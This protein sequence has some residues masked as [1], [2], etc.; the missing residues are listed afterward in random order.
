MREDSEKLYSCTSYILS[1]FGLKIVDCF[2]IVKFWIHGIKDLGF[3]KENQ[4]LETFWDDY[5]LS[6]ITYILKSPNA[7]SFFSI[8]SLTSV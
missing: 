7:L 2:F 8:S 4:R 6:F 5:F 3:D 1:T